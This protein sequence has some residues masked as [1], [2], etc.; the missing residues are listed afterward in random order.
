LKILKYGKRG[1]EKTREKMRRQQ[2]SRSPLL[3][4]GMGAVER[5]I[6]KK[7][8]LKQRS[9]IRFKVSFFPFISRLVD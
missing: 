5:V 2:E 8:E 3:C 1:Q 9:E 6:M 4:L 7:K